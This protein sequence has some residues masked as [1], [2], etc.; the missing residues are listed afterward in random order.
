MVE[1]YYETGKEWSVEI[2]KTRKK[3]IIHLDQFREIFL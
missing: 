1:V 3:F 2:L